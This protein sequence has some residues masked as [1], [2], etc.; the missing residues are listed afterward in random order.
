MAT[1]PPMQLAYDQEVDVLH[2]S[3]G[4]PRPAIS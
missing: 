3:V 1:L 2:L 4:D